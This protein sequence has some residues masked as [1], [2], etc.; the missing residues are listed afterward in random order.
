MSELIQMRNRITELEKKNARHEYLAERIGKNKFA[1]KTKA[2][3]AGAKLEIATK[4]LTMLRDT[5][6]ND[7]MSLVCAEEAR[8]ALEEMEARA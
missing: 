3:T 2:K 4:A 5:P 8:K 1:W 7:D 6:T